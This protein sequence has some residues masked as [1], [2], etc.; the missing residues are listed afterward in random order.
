VRERVG[1]YHINCLFFREKCPHPNP[2]PKGE[3]TV[4]LY[5]KTS[6]KDISYSLIF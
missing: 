6:S 4:F 2:L 5:F 1:K 3:G